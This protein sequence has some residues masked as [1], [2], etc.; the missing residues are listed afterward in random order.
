MVERLQEPLKGVT[1]VDL[2]GT[3]LSA[4]SMHIF[5]RRLPGMLMKRKAP[6]AA[7][8]SL[9][10]IGLRRMRIVSHRSMKWHL[11]KAARRHLLEEDWET[12]AE[13]MSAAVNPSVKD[14]IESRRARGCITYLATA[15]M[16]EYAE[17]LSRMMGYEGALTTKFTENISEYEELNRHAKH[18]AIERL[19][20][21]EGLRLESF[22]TDH[23]DD[24]PTAKA[25]P[26]LTILVGASAKTA[27]EFREAGITRY[28]R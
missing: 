19:L 3:L 18:G 27:D 21:E 24:L 16:E 11:T 28:L 1:I 22:L 8:S 14:Y 2:D 23:T 5:M 26:N 25:Y 15:A 12:L 9:W 13:E 20:N 17:P 10:Q 4:N 6:G 7:M